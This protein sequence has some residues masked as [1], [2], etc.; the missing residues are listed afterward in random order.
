MALHLRWT[1]AGGLDPGV[2]GASDAP[3]LRSRAIA[4]SGARARRWRRRWPVA[5]IGLWALALQAGARFGADVHTIPPAVPSVDIVAALFDLTP[6]A[7]PIATGAA[8]AEWPTTRHDISRDP[9]LWRRMHVMHWNDVPEPLRRSGLDAMLARYRGLL[10]NPRVWDGMTVHDWDEVPQPIRTMAYRQMVAYWAGFYRVGAQY[11]LPPGL[12]TDTLAAI[13]MT[14]SWFDH[15]AVRD[16]GNGNR[17]L[18]LAQA[19]D[20]ARERL[21]LLHAKGV[22][23]VAPSDEAYFNPWVATRFVAL[24]M[25]LLLD[26]AEGDLDLAVRAYHR[27]IAQA[28]GRLGAVYLDTVRQRLT[29]F[30]RNQDAGS[31][32]WSYLWVAGRALEREAWPWTARP[33]PETRPLLGAPE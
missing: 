19:S 24:W 5:A 20:F 14:E 27:G 10:A 31:P 29:A 6:M 22:A 8:R 25:S 23:D 1:A 26:E 16:D 12:V 28:R 32:A 18:G 11:E 13:V 2:V 17:D 3:R 15:R 33:A 30:I 4:A 7:V 21:R 9:A